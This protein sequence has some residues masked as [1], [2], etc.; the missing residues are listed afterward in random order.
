MFD[1]VRCDKLIDQ[2]ELPLSD[3]LVIKPPN[4]RFIV[5]THNGPPCGG[6]LRGVYAPQNRHVGRRRKYASDEGHE[7][8]GQPSPTRLEPENPIPNRSPIKETSVPPRHISEIVHGKA[9]GEPC[10]GTMEVDVAGTAKGVWAESGVG[11]VAGDEC[12]YITLADYPYR[13]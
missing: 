10:C 3:H 11:P 1:E 13:P 6:R 8:E 7:P 12:G 2:F 4:K 5:F 9:A